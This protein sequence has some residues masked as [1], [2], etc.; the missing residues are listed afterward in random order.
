M[1]E[2]NQ[3]IKTY[4]LIFVTGLALIFLSKTNIEITSPYISRT[5][6]VL[7]FSLVGYAPIRV[8]MNLKDIIENRR[9]SKSIENVFRW[10][11][12]EVESK[13]D[14]PIFIAA[15]I[16]GCI[17]PPHRAQIDLR[18]FQRLRGYCEFVKSS[19]SR[20]YPPI[21]I[22]TGRS[23]GYVELLAQSLGMMDSY[24]ELP[25]VIENG[26]ALYYPA[27]KQT[28]RLLDLGQMKLIRDIHSLLLDKLPNNEFEPKVFM[29]TINAIPGE[30]IDQLRQKVWTILKN[31][32][33]FDI[34]RVDSTASAVDITAK[35]ID[36][37]SGLKKVLEI[38]HGLRPENSD[39]G[40]EH[41]VAV[42]D[43][44]SDLCVLKEVGKAYCPAK[45]AHPEVTK[46]IT[47]KFGDE[48]IIDK[49]HIDFVMNVIER[50]T[51]IKII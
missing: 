6:E 34:L 45:D 28:K 4:L 5:F 50:E 14:L 7:G 29:V 43:S 49:S 16:E 9:A 23:Q 3:D 12:K 37:I 22:F 18:K 17:T 27:S 13:K 1:T 10:K 15:D 24:L 11:A 40:L 47:E 35:G 44:T 33:L 41:I 21:V 26:S 25:F 42:G 30:T 19:T 20:K 46:Y 31:E 48:Y 39:K 51:G 38:Y 32:N 2:D 36:K 8:I